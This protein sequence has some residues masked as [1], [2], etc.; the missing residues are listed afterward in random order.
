MSGPRLV[1]DLDIDELSMILDCMF[2]SQWLPKD[3]QRPAF[4]E[5]LPVMHRLAALMSA[6]QNAPIEFPTIP[7]DL[8]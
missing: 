7:G 3:V 6:A 8:A 2:G 4:A 5:V 1:V